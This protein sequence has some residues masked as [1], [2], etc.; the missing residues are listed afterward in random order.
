M[1]VLGRLVPAF[2]AFLSGVVLATSEYSV[3]N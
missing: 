2:G 1:D 3:M